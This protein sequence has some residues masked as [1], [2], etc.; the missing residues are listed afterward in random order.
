[1]L[2]V[3]TVCVCFCRSCP[4]RSVRVKRTSFMR[5]WDI[6][7]ASSQTHPDRRIEANATLQTRYLF[8]AYRNVTV[9]VN[10]QRRRDTGSRGFDFVTM[11]LNCTNVFTQMQFLKIVLQTVLKKDIS[12]WIMS[13]TFF[14]ISSYYYWPLLGNKSKVMYKIK[15]IFHVKSYIF[16]DVIFFVNLLQQTKVIIF[17]A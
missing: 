11:M 13:L 3:Q 4:A 15:A 6:I 1:M 5:S 2:C 14:N 7:S 10:V 17:I 16:Y 12:S 8:S 9:W